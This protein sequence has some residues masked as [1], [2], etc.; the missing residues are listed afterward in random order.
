MFAEACFE[1]NYVSHQLSR[2]QVDGERRPNWNKISRYEQL[3]WNRTCQFFRVV[4]H[5][6]LAT[7]Y[8]KTM[9]DDVGLA[10]PVLL[11]RSSKNW[12]VDTNYIPIGMVLGHG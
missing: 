3:G 11:A 10:Y 6:R 12:R 5:S 4:Y 1:N 8:R 9:K 7:C 2:L